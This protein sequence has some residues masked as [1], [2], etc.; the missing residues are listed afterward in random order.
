LENSALLFPLS[1]YPILFL[2]ELLY[3]REILLKAN[4]M[5]HLTY[6]FYFITNFYFVQSTNF[7][8]NYKVGIVDN[9]VGARV[10]KPPI[11]DTYYS[12]LIRGPVATVGS[13]RVEGAEGGEVWKELEQED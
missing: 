9:G 10:K 1:I 4:P 13:V 5:N 6:E 11:S 2:L 3:G 7:C 8:Y 12:S